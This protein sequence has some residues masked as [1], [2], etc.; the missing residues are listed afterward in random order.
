[1]IKSIV[2]WLGPKAALAAVTLCIFSSANAA[3][4]TVTASGHISSANRQADSQ[5]VRNLIEY[6][7]NSFTAN[8]VIDT[9]GGQ[10]T[11]P[12]NYVGRSSTYASAIQSGSSVGGFIGRRWGRL[13]QRGG[14]TT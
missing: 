3:I 12:P 13:V 11:I 9:E 5:F 6:I 4:V 2:S 1:M 7:G 14:L 10:L 8:F